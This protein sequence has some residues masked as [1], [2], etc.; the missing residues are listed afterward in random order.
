LY[1]AW[2]QIVYQGTPEAQPSGYDHQGRLRGLL[3]SVR[4]GTLRTGLPAD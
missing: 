2:L 1:K 3:F 4:A